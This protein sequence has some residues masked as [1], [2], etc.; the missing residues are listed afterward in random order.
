MNK[1]LS[2]NEFV[3]ISDYKKWSDEFNWKFYKKLDPI[4][5][6][7]SNTVDKRGNRIYF[8]LPIE[9]VPD[10]KI[11]Q[12]VKDYLNWFGYPIDDWNLG[13]CIDKDNRKIKIG[14]LLNKLG[15]TDLLKSYQRSR[16]NLIRD[17][18]NL[19]VVI[20]R[21]PYDILGASTNRGWTSCWNLQDKSYDGK[22]TYQLGSILRS[23]S[24]ICYLI[25]SGDKNIKNPI[26]RIVIERKFHTGVYQD[27]PDQIVP[28]N[29]VYGTDIVE[30]RKF[31]TDWCDKINKSRILNSKPH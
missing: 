20:C 12:D 14:R 10:K 2:L 18:S 24:L 17:T 9:S 21:H 26:S 13:I 15:K 8:D 7:P 30:F 31:V 3:N 25:R 16:D 23:G 19:K 28:D 27:V 6:D 1:I 22:Y 5:K 4:F 29:K 11:P